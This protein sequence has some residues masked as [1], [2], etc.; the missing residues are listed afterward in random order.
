MSGFDRKC[1][2]LGR[3]FVLSRLSKLFGKL[4]NV[5]FAV[6]FG[7][8]ARDG[9]TSH[10]VDIAVKFTGEAGLLDLGWVVAKVAEALN[11]SEDFVAVSYTHL[12]LPTKA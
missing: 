12:T 6:V 4:E 2:V 11:V 10:D 7:S 8:L 1:K 9:V 3:E 5:E